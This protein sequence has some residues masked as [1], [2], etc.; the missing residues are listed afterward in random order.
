MNVYQAYQ[1]AVELLDQHGLRQ[2]GRTVDMDDAK[3]R[4]GQCR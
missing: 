1:L 4:F 2:K 3:T